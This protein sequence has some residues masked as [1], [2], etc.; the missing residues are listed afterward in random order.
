MASQK[1]QQKV[2]TRDATGLVKNVSFIDAITLNL[3]NM[4]VG[5]GLGTIG[6]TTTLL[7]LAIVNG[8]FN[9]VLTS[10]LAFAL[11]IPQ[12]VVYTM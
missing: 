7:P 10:L 6:L 8:G 4:S 2:F 1:S 12:I 9:L 5:A 3:G 11:S